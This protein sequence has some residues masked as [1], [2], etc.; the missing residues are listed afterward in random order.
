MWFTI[1]TANLV[2]NYILLLKNLNLDAAHFANGLSLVD[3][4]N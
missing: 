4:A 3:L 1:E 2:K